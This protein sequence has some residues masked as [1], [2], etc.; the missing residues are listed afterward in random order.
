[1]RLKL[2]K[3]PG[4]ARDFYALPNDDV[5]RLALLKL[6]DVANGLVRGLPLDDRVATGDLSDCRK[7]YFDPDPTNPKPNY[8]LV[9][10][11]TPDEIHA[12]AVEAVSVG[13][14]YGLDAYL[15]AA[16]NLGRGPIH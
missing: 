3:L 7:L 8:R 13:E 15:R 14:R 12:V 6:S 10:R 9:Y 5:R 11:L 1:M 16:R 2:T 4:F